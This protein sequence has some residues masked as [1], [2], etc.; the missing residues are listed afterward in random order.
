MRT[1]RFAVVVGCLVLVLISL[2]VWAVRPKPQT[3]TGG[4]SVTF[5]G[6][7]NDAS[8]ATLVQ[9][10]VASSFSRRVQ[11]GV[12]EAQLHQKAEPDGAAADSGR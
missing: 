3:Q 6:L 10:R 11:L 9:F 5:A 7:T 2:I 12:D 1:R 4:L 8:G